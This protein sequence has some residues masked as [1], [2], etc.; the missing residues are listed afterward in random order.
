MKFFETIR[1]KREFSAVFDHGTLIQESLMI[2]YIRRNDANRARY[3][4][5][6]GKKIGNSVERNRIKRRLREIIRLHD[7]EIE[8]G[9]DIILVAR[10]SCKRSGYWPMVE[11]FRKLCVKAG[12]LAAGRS[13]SAPGPQL[14]S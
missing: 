4:I 11:K 3:G 10:A 7:G 12:I 1:K 13:P 9:H 14:P 5:C 6:V 8:A 2:M